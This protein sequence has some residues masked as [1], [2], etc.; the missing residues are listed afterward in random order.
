MN[1]EYEEPY[2]SKLSM[3]HMYSSSVYQISVGCFCGSEHKVSIV[4]SDIVECST[5]VR[6]IEDAYKPNLVCALSCAICMLIQ[7]R[8]GI[9]QTYIA[10]FV[11]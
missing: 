10:G 9:I 6:A 3:W 5:H 1:C 4:N 2:L 8:H 7:H 11:L